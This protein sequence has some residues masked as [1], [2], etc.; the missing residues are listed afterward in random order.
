M[1]INKTILYMKVSPLNYNSDSSKLII[2]VGKKHNLLKLLCDFKDETAEVFYDKL[3]WDNYGYDAIMSIYSFGFTVKGIDLDINNKC[4]CKNS[5]YNINCLYDEAAEKINK[6][7]KDRNYF[8]TYFPRSG[9]FKH[10]TTNSNILGM[11]NGISKYADNIEDINIK[12][13]NNE[14]IIIDARNIMNNAKYNEDMIDYMNILYIF[15]GWKSVDLN[16]NTRI[17]KFKK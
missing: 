4:V 10:K 2:Q 6:L 14:E 15:C 1:H 16:M 13:Y 8:L 7:K 9:Y 5:L 17:F 11:F 12:I 3:D